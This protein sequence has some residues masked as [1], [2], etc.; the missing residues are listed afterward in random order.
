MIAIIFLILPVIFTFL[1]YFSTSN[2]IISLIVGVVSGFYLLIITRK[3]ID[4]FI[5]KTK[6]YH[7]CYKFINSFL[8]SLSIRNTV[9]AALTNVGENMNEDYK[10]ELD[11]LE[12]VTGLEILTYLKKYYSFHIYNLFVNVVSLYEEQGGNVL[13]M[14]SL[15]IE[16]SRGIEDYINRLVNIS[17]KKVIEFSVLWIFAIVILVALRFVLGQF[18]VSIIS[19]L[20]FQ[21]AIAIIFIFVTI[22]IDILVKRIT[23]LEIRGYSNEEL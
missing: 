10:N 18:Y 11:G 14:S 1:T 9:G 6:R 8:I 7:R 12:D 13:N 5:R 19:Q 22:S 16:Q 3:R 2:I 4:R 20:I 23:K 17:K 15:I 21:I